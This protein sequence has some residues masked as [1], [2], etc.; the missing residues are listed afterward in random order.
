MLVITHDPYQ[1]VT[2][3]YWSLSLKYMANPFISLSSGPHPV[4]MLPPALTCST[5]GLS[6][7]TFWDHASHC[8]VIY[9][10]H[11]SCY[12]TCLLTL[13]GLPTTSKIKN[14]SPGMVKGSVHPGPCLSQ[15]CI[16]PL[17]CAQH[18]FLP[19][20]LWECFFLYQVLSFFYP[21]SLGLHSIL[22]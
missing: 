7:S 14:K 20:S 8:E 17:L 5:A 16:S 13:Q 15:D 3:V 2:R 19:K 1:S 22:P 12:V 18:F 21:I 9:L 6:T 4:S 10:L 11:K